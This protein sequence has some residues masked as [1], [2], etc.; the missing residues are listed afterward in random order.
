MENLFESYMAARCLIKSLRHQLEEFESGERYLKIQRDHSRVVA[1]YIKES[2]KMRLEI[3]RLNARLISTRDMWSEDYYA[4]YDE[5]QARV[6]KLQEKVRRCEDRIWDIQRE[7]DDRT[8]RMK[9]EYE[10]RLHEKDAIILEL[11]NRLAHA[12]ALLNTDGTNAGVPTSMTPIGKEK[13][14]PNTR[15]KTGKPK[16]GQAGHEKHALKRPDES[17]VTDTV[18]HCP[19]DDTYCPGC[20]GGNYVPTGEYEEKFEYNVTVNVEKIRH[21]FG[22]YR[23]LDCG[24]E[25]RMQIPRRL[26]EEAQYGSGVNALILSLGNT[27]NAAMNKTAMFLNGISGS[28]LRPSEG[29]IAKLQYRAA[30]GL[31]DFCEELK[32]VL[33]TRTVVYWDDSVIMINTKRACFRFYGDDKIAYYTAHMHKD[34]ESIDDDGVLALLTGGT[35]VMHDHNSINYN[36]KF[37]FE[38][39]ECNQHLQRD[40]QRNSDDTCHEWSDNLKKIIGQTIKDRNGLIRAGQDS[41]TPE[42]KEEFNR[43]LDECLELGWKENGGDPANYGAKFER[44]LL[45]RIDK[46]RSNYF[47]WTEDFR[48]PTTNNLSERGLRGIKSKMKI[49]GQFESEAAADNHA[50]IRTYIETCRR[51]GINEMH[52]LQRLCD[53]NPYTVAEIFQSESPP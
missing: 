13:R 9:L 10:D 42:Y 5:Q 31:V 30:Y 3:G 24:E 27:V 20:G 11:K 14:I 25:F 32:R 2:K 7:C 38:N 50:V 22:Y 41:F 12:E 33:I 4:L 15:E 45:R 39:I 17:E 21:V 37:A 23:C 28:E 16:G 52:A 51:N 26:K 47:R 48:L 8:D 35:S 44:T 46:Y 29:Y 40:C 53:G 18:E 1:G 49:S 43:K 6:R 19:D 36:E 34:M